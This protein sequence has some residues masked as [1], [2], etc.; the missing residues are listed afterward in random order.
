[1]E[2]ATKLRFFL[3]DNRQMLAIAIAFFVVGWVSYHFMGSHCPENSCRMFDVKKGIDITGNCREL[4]NMSIQT[5]LVK[6]DSNILTI[7]G[8]PLDNIEL[9]MEVEPKGLSTCVCNC[10][11]EM[12]LQFVTDADKLQSTT[13]STTTTTVYECPQCPEMTLPKETQHELLNLRPGANGNG[14]VSAGFRMCQLKVLDLLKLK[15]YNGGPSGTFYLN[16]VE[17]DNI[18][19]ETFMFVRHGNGFWL[20]RTGEWAWN[21]SQCMTS[22]LWVHKQ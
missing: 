7:G 2:S 8:N 10:T 20:N 13:A 17:P 18:E 15:S 14:A 21:D 9:Q 3:E 6:E 12:C 1:M 19:A 22:A 4:Y 16:K 5:G 11:Q